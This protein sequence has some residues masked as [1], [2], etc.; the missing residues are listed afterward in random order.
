[1][2]GEVLGSYNFF[3]GCQQVQN[4]ALQ[5]QIQFVCGSGGGIQAKYVR[6]D[7]CE[8]IPLDNIHVQELSDEQ[9]VQLL[10]GG[11]QLSD[12]VKTSVFADLA[13]QRQKEIARGIG[14]Q[15][16]V[17]V[18]WVRNADGHIATQST[19]DKLQSLELIPK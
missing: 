10:R 11:A 15:W 4:S 8:D 5:R 12:I 17:L 9:Q 1:M 16:D 14:K 7:T 3:A 19:I 13:A 2:S 18:T 6:L